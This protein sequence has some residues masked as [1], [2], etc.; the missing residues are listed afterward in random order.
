VDPS[1]ATLVLADLRQ[2]TPEEV[3]SWSST[4]RV[5]VFGPHVQEAALTE[6]SEAGAE[7]MS[8]SRFFHALPGLLGA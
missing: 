2:A 6:M 8:R 5:V 3:R 4:A 1:E 7:A